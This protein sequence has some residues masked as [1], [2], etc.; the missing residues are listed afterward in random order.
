MKLAHHPKHHQNLERQVKPPHQL[1]LQKRKLLDHAVLQ[2]FDLLL[3][4]LHQ[5]RCQAIQN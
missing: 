1:K 4:Q 3:A 2:W 5:P